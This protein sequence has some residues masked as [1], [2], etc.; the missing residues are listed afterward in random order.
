MVMRRLALVLL[1]AAW[2]PAAPAQPPTIGSYTPPRT[3]PGYRPPVSPYLSLFGP[4][5]LAVR[6]YNQVRPQQQFGAGIARN[7]AALAQPPAIGEP[8]ATGHRAYFFNFGHY[9]SSRPFGADAGATPGA[10]PVP[11]R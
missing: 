5:N 1:L 7:E 6:Y 11:G 8:P 2:A 10:R 3:A 9:Y 4:G